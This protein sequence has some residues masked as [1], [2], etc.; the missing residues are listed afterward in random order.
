VAYLADS[1]GSTVALADP[2]GTLIT[3][4]TY[5]PFGATTVSGFPTP[6]RFQ[7]T[8]RENDGNALYYY[9][10]RYYHPSS[11]RFL[12]EDPAGLAGGL[13]SYE[14]VGGSPLMYRDPQG[15][16]AYGHHYEITRGEATSAGLDSRAAERLAKLTGD[17]DTLPGSQEVENAPWHAMCPKNTV[18]EAGMRDIS[19]YIEQQIAT[20]TLEGLA[21]ALHAAQDAAA[22][23]H[24][25][26]QPWSGRWR[27]YSLRQIASHILGDMFP[28]RSYQ[29][30][31]IN[32]REILRRY[33]E[34]CQCQGR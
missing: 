18:P 6:N 33:Q 27:D 24:R 12:S 1:L 14:Y 28:D 30:A 3:E 29:E 23:G 21:R 11:H 5:E 15:L 2:A 13:N 17:V 7:F 25:G 26:C 32:S 9:R 10:A 31:V 4:Y 34:R 20:C 19:A 16:L 22:P 8:G